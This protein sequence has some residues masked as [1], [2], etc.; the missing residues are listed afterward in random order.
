MTCGRIKDRNGYC[1]SLCQNVAQSD[2]YIPDAI[3]KLLKVNISELLNQ[4]YYNIWRIEIFAER[5]TK[6]RQPLFYSVGN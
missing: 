3:A 2:I 4:H 5:F 6:V 1:I